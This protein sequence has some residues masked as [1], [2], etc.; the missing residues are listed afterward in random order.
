MKDQHGGDTNAPSAWE[1]RLGGRDRFTAVVIGGGINGIAVLRDLA[2]QGV[3][4]LLVE[5]GDFSSGASAASSH[6]VHGGLRYLEN[7]ELRLVQESVRERN[8]LLYTAPH[9]VVPLATTIPLRTTWSGILAAPLRVLRH[10]RGRGPSERGAVL[11]KLGLVM[12]DSYSRRSGSLPRHDFDGA[13]KSH[14][15]F[16]DL[17]PDI[18]Y[19]ATYYDASVGQPERVA[20]DLVLDAQAAHSSVRAL[21]YVEAVGLS[22]DGVEIACAVTGARAT[23]QA[24]VVINASG[25]WTDLT[26]EALGGP[27]AFMGGT[28]G[29]HIVVDN[30]ALLEA[31]RGHEIFFEHPDGRIVLIY[32]LHGRVMIGTTD[33]PADPA[34]PA[35]CTPEEVEY[36]IDLVKHVFPEI[37]IDKRQIVYRFAGIR[38]LPRAEDTSPGAVSRDYRVEERQD[39]AG[40]LVLSIVGGK[41]TTFR[42]LGE[43]VT[44]A[45]LDHLGRSRR[46]HTLREPI[47]G[48][49]RFPRAREQRAAWIAER[50]HGVS[51]ERAE[52]LFARYGTRAQE[53]H[54]HLITEPDTLL[55][56]GELSVREIEYMVQVEHAR[57]INDVLQRRTTLAFTGAVTAHT[58][59]E[60]G[61]AM[62]RAL[63]WSS[64]ELS[65]QVASCAEILADEHGVQL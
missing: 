25:P 45:V 58:V 38:P 4:A 26:N 34:E 65:A 19:T 16:P 11:A 1:A 3:D 39:D 17:A 52:V 54:D 51:P 21:N 22:A 56:A 48:G 42:A 57:T 63:G 36:F 9:H 41:W 64:E 43:R 27:T 33:L 23:V 15:R 61:A 20:I 35:R 2:L 32:P 53:V 49:R 40:R 37:P 12:Y 10:R 24:D 29:S 62:A 60:V 28:K 14:D 18:A 59:D 30:P 46:R 13:T 8:S 5:R 6:M 31:T 7:G 44:D 55:A 47:G 50:L